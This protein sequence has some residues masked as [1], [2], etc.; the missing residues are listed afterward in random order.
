MASPSGRSVFDSQPV[1]VSSTALS[2]A[3]PSNPRHVPNGASAARSRYG[4]PYPVPSARRRASKMGLNA[5]IAIPTSDSVPH[6]ASRT[7]RSSPSRQAIAETSAR[8]SPSIL[9]LSATAMSTYAV[10]NWRPSS[11]SPG[12]SPHGS[13][14]AISSVP[15]PGEANPRSPGI[16]TRLGVCPVRT[17]D[18]GSRTGSILTAP[19]SSGR[20]MHAHRPCTSG[21]H[22][23]ASN[24]AVPFTGTPTCTTT[25]T[26]ASTSA[27]T[28]RPWSMPR[29]STSTPASPS[30]VKPPSGA[31][32]FA[33]SQ[34]IEPSTS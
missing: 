14:S 13:E 30:V 29:R 10:P 12:I 31:S 34:P 2:A 20:A 24:C 28:C 7:R 5:S 21:K 11:T 23:P 18:S 25:A 32:G 22:N 1:L 4:P 6:P 15:A 8:T 16:P 9:Q 17:P 27:V 19:I 33:I 26:H 3:G